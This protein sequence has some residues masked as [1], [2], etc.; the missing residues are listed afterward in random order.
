MLLMVWLIGAA[1]MP[2]TLLTAVQTF[3]W[4]YF[5]TASCAADK[6]EASDGIA[7]DR[8]A[9]WLI[10]AK[11]WSFTSNRLSTFGVAAAISLCAPMAVLML[12]PI[13]PRRSSQRRS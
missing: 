3:F 1:T 8:S 10:D 12:A 13:P 5:S 9:I 6:I 4:A 11:H 2:D 7:K